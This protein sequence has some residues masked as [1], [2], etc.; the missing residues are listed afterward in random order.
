MTFHYLATVH[1][2]TD[3]TEAQSTYST[4]LCI[5]IVADNNKFLNTYSQSCCVRCDLMPW[6]C[7]GLDIEFDAHQSAELQLSCGWSTSNL[8]HLSLVGRIY[9]RVCAR[10]ETDCIPSSTNAFTNL[11][12]AIIRTEIVYI[13]PKT[14]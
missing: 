12:S 8:P 2:S 7:H 11:F 5:T 14:K 10:A 3:L 1:Y 6:S 4:T 13:T 9:V